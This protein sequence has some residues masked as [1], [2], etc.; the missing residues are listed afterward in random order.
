MPNH[1]AQYAVYAKIHSMYG[2]RIQKEA[3]R[4]LLHKRTLMEFT[5]YLKANTGYQ[6]LLSPYQ[7][8]FL[9]REQLEELLHQNFYQTYHR[10]LSFIPGSKRT[11]L[12][13]QMLRNE[14][15][16][17]IRALRAL[18]LGTLR[19]SIQ[20]IPAF[21]LSYSSLDFTKL[22]SCKSIHDFID[23][24]HG[25]PYH[26][27][28]TAFVE[29]APS[30][31]YDHCEAALYRFYYDWLFRELKTMDDG[32]RQEIERL[33][34]E[35]IEFSNNQIIY[36][37]KHYF[38]E[39]GEQ[40]NKQLILRYDRRPKAFLKRLCNA[41]AAQDVITLL[42]QDLRLTHG[43]EAMQDY[44]AIELYQSL[45]AYHHIERL[46]RMSTHPEV[47]FIAFIRL[48]Q[49]ELENLIHIIEGIRY[50]LPR[51][52]LEEIIIA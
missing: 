34:H 18:E 39:S 48:M 16:L 36:R 44:T 15:D 49:Y 21:L 7:D 42:R 43:G 14:I 12:H 52:E 10:L 40:I 45:E 30:F 3:Y 13:F 4:E 28:L 8:G 37:M 25:R 41:D 17:V 31:R 27:V 19:D 6:A 1:N 5:A 29:K 32:G 46:F 51:S 33:F 23:L 2:Q 50:D 20:H 38:H 26:P 22:S 47:V 11:L 24:L 9:H 35:Q